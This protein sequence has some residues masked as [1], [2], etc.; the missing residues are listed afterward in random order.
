[1]GD[2][3]SLALNHARRSVVPERLA[4]NLL[5]HAEVMTPADYSNT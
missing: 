4:D 2:A 3:E 1:M 5:D